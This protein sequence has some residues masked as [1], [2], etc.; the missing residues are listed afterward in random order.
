MAVENRTINHRFFR[1]QSEFLDVVI[2]I[3]AIESLWKRLFPCECKC[4]ST[5]FNC[6]SFDLF[7]FAIRGKQDEGKRGQGGSSL[8]DLFRRLD[9]FLKL[10][11]LLLRKIGAVFLI[12]LIAEE[13]I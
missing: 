4:A 5:H 9:T 2:L 12:S 7:S 11:L 3:F 1:Q 8:F 10:F 13:N 6:T